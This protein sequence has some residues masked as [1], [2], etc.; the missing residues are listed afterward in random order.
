MTKSRTPMATP[1][2]RDWLASLSDAVLEADSGSAT[3]DSLAF[4]H[5]DRIYVLLADQAVQDAIELAFARSTDPTQVSRK[6]D[7]MKSLLVDACWIS[8]VMPSTRQPDRPSDAGAQPASRSETSRDLVAAALQARKLAERLATLAP[9]IGRGLTLSYLRERFDSEDRAG[10][11]AKRKGWRS[12]VAKSRAPHEPSVSDLLKVLSSD[13]NEEAQLVKK[14]IDDKRQTGGALRHQYP[15]IDAL[16]RTSTQLGA[17]DSNGLPCPD[18]QLVHAILT[19]IYPDN[20]LDEST[21]RRR[22]ARQG[23]PMKKSA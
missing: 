8:H 9:H 12:A 2:L 7:V 11:I 13:L 16:S 10:F 3:V 5:R 22:W 21:L 20:T 14:K 1:L 4:V 6:Q 17:R 18:F 19:S 15:L 23:K